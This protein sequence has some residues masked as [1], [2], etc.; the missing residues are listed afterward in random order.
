MAV[1]PFVVGNGVVAR[2]L[3]RAIV[4]GRGL[5]PTGVAVPEAACAARGLPAYAA[6]LNAYVTG[7]P[8]GLAQWL[9]YCAEAVQAGA[10][11]GASV[12]DAV[13]AGRLRS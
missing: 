12:A 3:F 5:D 2:A 1:R 13:L 7:T 4:V 11:E 6:A 8:D 10:A 9:R